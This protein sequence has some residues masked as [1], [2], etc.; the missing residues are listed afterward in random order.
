M[1]C[2]TVCVGGA[3]KLVDTFNLNGNIVGSVGM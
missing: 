3:V 2:T 1:N